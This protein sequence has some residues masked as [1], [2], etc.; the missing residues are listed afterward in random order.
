MNTSRFTIPQCITR[1]ALERNF[2]A[3]ASSTK[4][5]TFF[6]V[7]IQPPLLGNDFNQLGNMANKAKGRAN[8]IPNPLIPAVS[9]HAPALDDKEP[10]NKEPR[11]GPVQEKETS[12]SVSAIKKIPPMLPS[13]LL[14]AVLEV[15]LPGKA[16]SKKPKNERA[17]KIKMA[18]KERFTHAL[19]EMVLNISGLISLNK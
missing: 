2:R 10:T 5:S 1:S 11:M 6:T 12:A 13:S 7:S 18:K 16:I 4:A 9:C 8:A 14:L 17:K 3:R 15:K 19:V